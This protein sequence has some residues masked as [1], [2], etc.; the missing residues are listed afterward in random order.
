[1]NNM[2]NNDFIG[3]ASKQ[4]NISPDKLTKAMGGKSIDKAVDEM[5]PEQK[6]MLNKALSDK[7]YAKKILSSP[8]AQNLIRQL[9]GK[10]NKS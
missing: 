8:E 10:K 2:N 3:K 9:S 6:E 4:L 7:D 5:S 1:M